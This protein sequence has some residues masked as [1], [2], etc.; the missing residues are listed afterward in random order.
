MTSRTLAAA[1]A[2]A[3][4]GAACS[5]LTPETAND[6]ANAEVPL[7]FHR[8]IGA[9]SVEFDS[10]ALAWVAGNT[11]GITAE[12]R[13]V[14]EAWERGKPEIDPRRHRVFLGSSDH[15]LYALRAGDGSVIW[16]FETPSAVQS[17]PLYDPEM[18]TVYFGAHD[19]ALYCVR[20]ATGELVWRHDSGAEVAKKPV[21]DGETLYFANAADTLVAVDR[22][23][24]KTR[25]Q[26]HR[27]P[28]LGMEVAGYAG[29]TFD[30][31]LVYMAYS[32]GHVMAYDGRDGTEKWAPVDLA[33]DA[34]Q[35]GEAVR[36]LDVDTTPVVDDLPQGRVVY[37]ASY[38][39]GV[40][41]LD[42][43][44]GSRVWT[45]DK[46]L[47]VTDLL[48]FREPA[49]RAKGDPPGAPLI[50]ER[51]VLIA[52][53]ASTGLWGLDPASGGRMLWR[54]RVPE[55]GITAPVA[56]AGALLVGTT[57]YGAFL[58]SP[59]NGKV[60]D[61]LE[62]GGGFAHTPAAYGTRAYLFS[63]SGRFLGLHIA[64][65]LEMPKP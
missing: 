36:Y 43:H 38:A 63:N 46:A 26:A 22:R 8:P 53:S 34:E 33:A 21:R 28:A 50:P 40:V 20:A 49:H 25:W 14:G 16:R 30:R 19:G 41:A 52:S 55:G 13:K 51:R 32:D 65:P 23:S 47:G 57:R 61:G 59:L 24:G 17:E 6:R 54:N 4:A 64:P 7:W 29:P 3:L 58:V 2:L 44:T 27:Q 45:N 11:H 56:V 62:M 18:D 48:L 35:G 42:A 1:S 39:G 10:A 15:G 37:V 9:I 12:S 31:G 5:T 60:I